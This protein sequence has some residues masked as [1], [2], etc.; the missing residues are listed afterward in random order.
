VSWFAPGSFHEAAIWTQQGFPTSATCARA[1]ANQGDGPLDLAQERAALAA[2]QRRQIE[3]KL[4]RERDGLIPIELIERM[5]GSAFAEIKAGLLGQHNIIASEHP[6]I[7]RE[8]ILGILS[9]NRGLLRRLAETPFPKTLSAELVQLEHE[10]C[11]ES[12]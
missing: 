9:A 8:A 7:P 3:I 6:E 12:G 4:A 10:A 11:D 1:A 2:A 5:L